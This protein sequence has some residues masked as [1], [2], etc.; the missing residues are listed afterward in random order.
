LS[1]AFTFSQ[2][3]P[4]LDQIVDHLEKAQADNHAN[5]R[6]Y[7]VTRDFRILSGDHDEKTDSEVKATVSF[8]PPDRQTFNIDS[9]TGNERGVAAV[10][11]ILESETEL[12]D[13]GTSA[14]FTRVNYDFAFD[15]Q[16][17]ADG[18]PAYILRITPKHKEKHLVSGRL[19]IDAQTYLPRKVEGDLAKSPSWWVKNVHVSMHFENVNG[20]WLQSST[21]AIA[22]LRIFGRHTLVSQAMNFNAGEQVASAIP[23]AAIQRVA[24]AT[25]APAGP[26]AVPRRPIKRRPTRPVPA[27]LGTGVLINQ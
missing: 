13:S 7:T 6:P 23:P 15:A 2:A 16:G 27:I 1:V 8:I 4:T 9:A 14:G 25:T 11:R 20:M 18:R 17:T 26:S 12:R 24:A 10:K 3:A 19:W 5:L 21:E 22:D